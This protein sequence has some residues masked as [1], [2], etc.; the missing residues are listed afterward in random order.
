VHDIALRIS[1]K[2]NDTWPTYIRRLTQFGQCTLQLGWWVNTSL[3]K[4][5]Q[6]PWTWLSDHW[7]YLGSV[8]FYITVYAISVLPKASCFV[9][10]FTISYCNKFY[11]KIQWSWSMKTIHNLNHHCSLITSPPS[12]SRLSRKC[13]SLDVSHPY[14][15]PQPVT[16]IAFLLYCSCIFLLNW[17]PTSAILLSSIFL[18]ILTWT[19]GL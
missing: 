15:P 4:W 10:I 7:H 3:V 2:T 18:H 14:M 8:K 6:Y 12:E 1:I 5:K 11:V 9:G 17:D 13:G 19:Q 16:E